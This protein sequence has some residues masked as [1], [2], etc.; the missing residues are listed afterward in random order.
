MALLCLVDQMEVGFMYQTRNSGFENLEFLLLSLTAKEELST[1]NSVLRTLL[2]I[3]V[4]ERLHGTLGL[5]AK[6]L[7][8]VNAGR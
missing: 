3:V 4:E 8:M 2:E 5:V 6:R 7:G 1:T